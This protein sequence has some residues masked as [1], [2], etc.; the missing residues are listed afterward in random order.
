VIR[1][2]SRLSE[3]RAEE[4]LKICCFLV[5][6]FR[7]SLERSGG[8]NL[9]MIT[10]VNIFK[11]LQKTGFASVF[12]PK[13]PRTPK[14]E[15]SALP[16]QTKNATARQRKTAVLSEIPLVLSR[17]FLLKIYISER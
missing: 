15:G 7:K 3:F 6:I 5:S 13:F 4:V 16:S 11:D 8:R 2:C 12:A 1:E 17:R 9:P 10:R 14:K